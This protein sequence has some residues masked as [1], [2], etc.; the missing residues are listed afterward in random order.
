MNLL[1]IYTNGDSQ[2]TGGA[3]VDSKASSRLI[4]R[5]AHPF[6]LLLSAELKSVPALVN[7]V[8][9]PN[10]CVDDTGC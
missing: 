9:F 4:G 2:V 3:T 5:R 6:L 8:A 7:T 1:Q 10:T